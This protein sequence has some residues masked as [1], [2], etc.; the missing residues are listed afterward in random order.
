MRRKM[1]TTG[2]VL[3]I[4][5]F[6]LCVGTSVF[7]AGTAEAEEE[8]LE[9]PTRPITIVTPWQVGGAAEIAARIF[10]GHLSEELG[11][12]V[13]VVSKTG[14]TGATGTAFV[15]NSRPDGYT[16]LQ[17]FIGPFA[18][19]PLYLGEESQYDPL[20]DFVPLGMYALE[21]VVFLAERSAPWDTMRDFIEDARANPGRYA[22]GAGG[23]LSL[24]ALY[25]GLLYDIEGID[26]AVVAYP[27][28]LA[29]V[30]D[31]LGGDLHTIAGNPTGLNLY[32]DLKALAV[33]TPER[34]PA[35]PDVPTLAEQGG[36]MDAV[37]TWAGYAVHA[38]TPEPILRILVDAT[39]RIVNS[40]EF[41][42]DLRERIE[43]TVTY[44][45]PDEFYR[46]WN[47]SIEAMA[48]AVEWLLAKQGEE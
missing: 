37:A 3:L 38:D 24:H 1:R 15:K 34:W 21:P 42:R 40:A 19:V 9:Y 14:G 4:V 8:T 12:R 13:D 46:L 20:E 28:A 41:Q 11:V 45:A 7:A 48:P 10:A 30:S 47:D 36:E 44:A 33:L 23:Q 26:V 27:G 6:L 39:D 16:I 25:A 31:L 43:V 35:L 29:G 32:E 2:T 17:A 22:T 5:V 18:Q